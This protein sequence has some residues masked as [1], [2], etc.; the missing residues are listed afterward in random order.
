[1]GLSRLSHAITA[2]RAACLSSPHLFQRE[3]L[4]TSLSTFLSLMMLCAV[5]KSQSYVEVMR[6]MQ[7]LFDGDSER[8]SSPSASAFSQARGKLPA[9]SCR[10]IWVAV[11]KAVRPLFARDAE[12]RVFGLRPLAVDGTRAITPHEASTIARW[13]RPKL[14]DGRFA[15]HPQVLLVFAFEL[16]S[17]LPV[18]V[19]VLG[20]KASEHLGLRELLSTIGRN[21]LLILDRGYVGKAL[22]R[23]MIA[24][25]NQVLLRMTTA[26][27]NSWDCVYKFLR[28]K[29]KDGLVELVLPCR[30][31]HDEKP[32]TV[33]VRLITRSFPRGRP[34]KHQGR[35]KMVLL[36]TLTD[37]NRAPREDLIALYSERWGIETFNRELKIIYQVERFRSRT[38][39]RVE[40][41]LYACLTWLTIAAATQSAAD[42]AIRRL[43]GAQLWNNPTRIQVRRTYLF[44]IVTDWFQRLMT[45]VVTA[46]GLELAMAKDIADLVRYAAKRRPNRSESR[47]R[48]NPNGR[49][50]AN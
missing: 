11:L 44:T 12:R 21:N 27:A 20:H 7:P 8:S 34:R 19:A 22:L 29:Q 32:L 13:P 1:M 2:C 40:Q 25:G 10:A 3:R 36:T 6:Q 33:I 30:P 23:D 47:V 38:A 31:G 14:G 28:T 18:G 49:S 42:Q 17:R 15:H 43:H 26:E 4:F 39:E 9:S 5:K 50:R 46:E 35:E 48:K 45:G 24:S 41:E 16:F 37:A